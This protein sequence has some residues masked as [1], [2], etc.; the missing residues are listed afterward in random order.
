MTLSETDLVKTLKPNARPAVKQSSEAMFT[1]RKG[2]EIDSQPVNNE[3]FFTDMNGSSTPVNTGLPQ[4]RIRRSPSSTPSDS[5]EE[6]IVF[7]GRRG[8][9]D[10]V[11]GGQNLTKVPEKRVRHESTD[12]QVPAKKLGSVV[13]DDPLDRTSREA[14]SKHGGSSEDHLSTT[15]EGNGHPRGVLNGQ[16]GAR[17]R[18]TQREKSRR[19]SAKL[20]EEDE[21]FADY[22]ANIEDI[23]DLGGSAKD[24]LFNKRDLGGSDT[25]EWQD[26]EES[27]V[28][29][30]EVDA[31]INAAEHWDSADLQDFDELS[32]SEEAPNVIAQILHVR[33]RSSGVQYLVVGEGF[34]IDDARWLPRSALSMPGISE[35]IQEFEE[36]HADFQQLLGDSDDSDEALTK[37]EQVARDLQEQVDD[38]EDERDLE[39][40]RLARM[41]DEQIARLL[42]KQEELGLG[43]D[44]LM[45]FNAATFDDDEKEEVPQFDGTTTTIPTAF[46][47]VLDQDP[48]NGFDVMDHERPSLRK[49]PKGRRGKLPIEL[50]DSELEQTLN[51]AWENDRSKKKVRKQ[52]R[53]VLRAQGLLG[54]NGKLDMKAKYSEGGG[55]SRFP[56]LYK[57]SKTTQYDEEALNALDAKLFSKRFLP[58]LD[59]GRKKTTVSGKARGGGFAS[60]GVS[61]RD[62]EIVGATAPEL[63]QEN[64]GRA[65]LEKMGW[66]TGKA[67]GALNNDRGIVQP[68]SQVVKTTKAGL[69]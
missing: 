58:R 20:R 22:I 34:T 35:M 15:K 37:D 11:G 46:T 54:K 23:D 32:T 9:Q 19:A 38:M 68:V 50:S 31:A 43:S 47:A 48:Y 61:Y 26:E 28:F 6:I 29:E 36:E 7:A 10:R 8:A 49:T 67:L 12:T 52:E 3:M 18:K 63:G 39:E 17:K 65:M 42:A 56:V 14:T 30:E 13:I 5:S 60:A 25:A 45:L 4:P 2:R 69:G 1:E 62:G 59:K 24:P 44:S 53:E 64:R 51:L 27:S 41:T 33:E 21:I 55:V 57:T 40:R 16:Q 66:S